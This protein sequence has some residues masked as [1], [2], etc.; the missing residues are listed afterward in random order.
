MELSPDKILSNYSNGTLDKET[1]I[2]KL[3]DLI[4][5]SNFHNI[6]TEGVNVLGKIG[7]KSQ[8]IF[9]L[10]ENLLIS[11]SDESVRIA[12]A[13]I[14]NRDY[15]E[16]A[17]KPINW[18][19]IYE[20]SPELLKILYQTIIKTL[21]FLVSTN[22]RSMLENGLKYV[23]NSEFKIGYETLYEQ[24]T[25]EKLEIQELSDILI[26]FYTL[27]FFKK[28]FWRIQY[29][30]S[31]S[32][33]IELDFQFKGLKTVPEEI[34]NLKFLKKLSLRYNQITTIPDWIDS[35]TLLEELDLY[36]NSL[37]SLPSSIGKLRF[38]KFLSLNINK[39]EELPNEICSLSHLEV[40][41]LGLNQ[42]KVIPES[43]GDLISLKKLNLFEN[44]L[45]FLPASLGELINLEYLNVSCNMIISLPESLG[46]LSKL[47][48]LNCEKNKLKSIP[49]F[50][51][52]LILLEYLNISKNN[53]VEIPESVINLEFLKEFYFGGNN[54]TQI[55]QFIEKL[56]EKGIQV[57][58]NYY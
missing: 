56:G 33:I 11:D 3:I 53:L 50:I 43:I 36:S 49:K 35:L 7:I 5:N 16:N 18:A 26:N 13:R 34:K 38:L 2:E 22:S 1:T 21:N 37:T 57:Y 40:L 51:K 9:N 8:N 15:Y 58:P 24:K 54:L 14:I 23:K 46:N 25:I 4:E 20:Y 28:K 6:R 29:K 17:F 39:L 41:D 52:N 12:A 19:L 48:V 31:N 32:K 27:L 55:P 30:I 42:L 47:K 45:T 10:L 44:Y